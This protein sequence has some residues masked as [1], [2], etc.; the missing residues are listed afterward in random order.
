MSG[1]LRPDGTAD[2]DDWGVLF[3]IF[4][5]FGIIKSAVEAGQGYESTS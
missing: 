1:K 3:E 5:F 2:L 4:D